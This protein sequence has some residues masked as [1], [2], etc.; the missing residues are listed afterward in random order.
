MER[1][2]STALD[3][4]TFALIILVE[5][6]LGSNEA[7]DNTIGHHSKGMRQRGCFLMFIMD[8][9]RRFNPSEMNWGPLRIVSLESLNYDSYLIKFING[10][11]LPNRGSRYA[12]AV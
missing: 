7:V 3:F 10:K 2:E 5:K 1:S 4:G 11:Y 8:T 12:S 6:D 9:Y